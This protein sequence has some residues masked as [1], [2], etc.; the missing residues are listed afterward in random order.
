[1]RPLN[2]NTFLRKAAWSLGRRLYCWARGDLPND[3][4]TNGEYWLLDQVMREGEADLALFD[5]GANR[6]D[7]TWHATQIASR[8]GR[9]ASVT[10]FE[11]CRDTRAMLQARIAGLNGVRVSGLAL[12][13][14]SGT[15][16]FFSGGAGVGTNSLSS[17]S[18]SDRETV[19]LATVDEIAARHGISDLSM[20][21]IDTEGFDFDVLAGAEG[22]LAA[23]K[24]ELV[25]FEYNWR[26]LPNHRSLR[27][28]FDFVSGKPYLV[29]KLNGP[30]IEIYEAWHFE[31]D[32]YFENNYLL[33]RKDSKLVQLGRKFSFD[34]SNIPFTE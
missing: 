9:R 27:D 33:I 16:D 20:I 23:G 6:G 8:L 14:K 13:S 11:P 31:M 3:P 5:V 32:R 10:A 7:W 30:S 34:R 26:W 28:V 12:S 18:G 19:E 24:V 15:A 21:K 1:M 25:Q 22:M 29:G 2:Q 4:R 17:I